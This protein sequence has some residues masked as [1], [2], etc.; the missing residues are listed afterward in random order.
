MQTP[1]LKDPN[2][3]ADVTATCRSNH[4][5]DGQQA[6]PQAI[7]RHAHPAG[8]RRFEQAWPGHADGIGRYF[9]EPLSQHDIGEL[10]KILADLIRANEKQPS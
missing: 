2:H 8:R 4:L 6:R 9:V 1:H 5:A 3:A 10:G 7:R